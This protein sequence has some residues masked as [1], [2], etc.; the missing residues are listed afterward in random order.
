MG[1]SL[2]PSIINALIAGV[3]AQRYQ[4]NSGVSRLGEPLRLRMRLPFINGA[5]T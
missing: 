1:V 2:I 5:A 4:A 3:A